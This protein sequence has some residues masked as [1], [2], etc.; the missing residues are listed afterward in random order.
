MDACYLI[1]SGI[2]FGRWR[3]GNKFMTLAGCDGCHYR[4]QRRAC[5]RRS[6]R[7]LNTKQFYIFLFYERLKT[8]IDKHVLLSDNQY[9]F[10][11]NRST[12]LALLE[13]VEKITKSIDDGKY[14]IGIFMDIKKAFDTIDHN[15]L[16]KKLHFLGVMGVANSW[17]TSYLS[18]RM[19][20]VEV[21]DCMSDLL[22]VKCG[23][24]QGSV[25]GHLLFIL[26]IN[27]I[28]NVSKVFDCILFADDTNLFCSDNDINDLCGI[29]NVEL[30][31]LSTWF[32]VNKLSLNI[33]K[34]HYIVFG[35]KTIDGKVSVLINNKIID[36]VYESK[37]LGVYIDSRINWKYHIDKTRC[38]LSRSISILYKSSTV[39]DLHNLYIIYS[40]IMMSYFSYC[41]E[42][43]GGTYDSNIKA[44][45]LLQ[46]RAIRVVCKCSKYDH[47]NILFSK[48]STL[49]LKDIIKYKTGIA[50]YRAYNNFLPDNVQ[51]LITTRKSHYNT[52]NSYNSNF[53]KYCIRTN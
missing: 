24:P 37:F 21:C 25:L 34:T 3:V 31:K 14:T 52:R 13:R 15:I 4:F 7:P 36:R 18:K 42:I 35:N 10:R 43:L 2:F 32:S 39:L 27:D 20:Y 46:K 11:S 48:L 26:Y 23:V 28:C 51:K 44:L 19:Q 47:T 22:Q 12:T 17:L 40:S 38:K 1:S 50:M 33:Q 16:L 8:Y 53:L 6:S 29:I 9:G 49:K 45:I 5:Q 30:D 41:S